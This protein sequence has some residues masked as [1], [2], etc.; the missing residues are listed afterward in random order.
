VLYGAIEMQEKINQLNQKL[1]N[2]LREPLK[3]GIG[4][5]C[6]QAIVGTMGPPKTPLL[7]A[8]GDNINIAARLES[9]TKEIG[10][11]LIVSVQ[12][13]EAEGIDFVTT[14]VQEIEVRGRDNQVRVCSFNRDQLPGGIAD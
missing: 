4:I 13:M 14:S 6:G 9:Q 3:I 5:H 7:T 2:E 8:V 1:E 11:D 10:C 12:T